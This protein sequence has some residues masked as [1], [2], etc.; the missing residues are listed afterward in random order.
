MGILSK[1]RQLAQN[2]SAASGQASGL[3]NNLRSLDGVNISQPT[4][5]LAPGLRQV[6]NNPSGEIIR[7]PSLGTVYNNDPRLSNSGMTASG[8]SGGGGGSGGSGYIPARS[9]LVPQQP[10]YSPRGEQSWLQASTA[11]FQA[12]V[13]SQNGTTESINT[14]SG[15]L[16]SAIVYMGN[17]I[18]RAITS[19]PADGRRQQRRQG[20]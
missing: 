9:G 17:V 3:E 6:E 19:N 1:T 2:L 10:S 15:S 11:G 12:V 5:D 13:N 20:L 7:R 18:A 14:L 16:T 8:G 4:V